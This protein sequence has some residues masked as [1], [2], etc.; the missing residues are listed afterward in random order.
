M[1]RYTTNYSP[2]NFCEEKYKAPNEEGN[3]AQFPCSN[4]ETHSKNCMFAY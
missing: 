4:N 2:A 3:I 1:K